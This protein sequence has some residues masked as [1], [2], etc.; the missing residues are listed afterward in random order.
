MAQAKKKSTG[1]SMNS[2]V[3]A[4]V[5]SCP[6]CGRELKV[7]AKPTTHGY[8]ASSKFDE[9]EKC[10]SQLKMGTDGRVTLRYA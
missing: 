4:S 3:V 9:C 7:Y 5:C 6:A 8:F 2:A 10:Q 1:R